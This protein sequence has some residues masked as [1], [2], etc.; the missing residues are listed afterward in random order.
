MSDPTLTG[1]WPAAA[2][3]VSPDVARAIQIVNDR[4][5]RTA[6]AYAQERFDRCKDEL[7][8]DP[9]RSGDPA[10][11]VSR[12]W[13]NAGKVLR[14]RLRRQERYDEA[15]HDRPDG[16]ASV[17]RA[18][19]AAELRGRLVALVE[20]AAMTASYRDALRRL[21]RGE[22]ADDIAAAADIPVSR[23]R[24]LVSRARQKIRSLAPGA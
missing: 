8:R 14:N 9:G 11:L 18:V 22:D 19:E 21:L 7:L 13:G 10:K 4:E 6:R 5:S 12:A 20:S 24:V 1:G 2:S 3:G 15:R 17:E 23:A 16:A